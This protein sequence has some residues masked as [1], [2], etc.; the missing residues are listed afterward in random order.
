MEID[1]QY[2]DS[3]G[4]SEVAF[5]FSYI[6][7]F[8]LL[9][10]LKAIAKQ[11]L[12]LPATADAAQYTH[13]EPILTRAIDWNLIRQQYDEIIKYTTALRLGTAEPEAI[14]SRFTRANAIHPTYK[15]LAELGKAIK[16][17]FL[18]R[19]LHDESLRREIHEGLNVVENWNSANDFIF[20]GERGEFSTNRVEDQEL[21]VLSLH[22]LQ[23]CLVYVNTLF[24]QEVLAEPVWRDRMTVDD[25]R[26]I[27]PLIYHHV[28]PY[29]RIELDMARR[30]ALAA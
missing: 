10:R 15:A 18:C 23:V 12:Y 4:Q 17:I 3:H 29:G 28:N 30:L 26:A 21:G 27:T 16:T 22:L 13:L 25:W 1:R 5:A 8:D 24:I 9:P 6:L 20:Y 11:K 14:L 19:Y 7:G 2:V